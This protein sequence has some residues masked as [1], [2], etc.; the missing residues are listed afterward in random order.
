MRPSKRLILF[1][2]ALSLCS[3][4][5]AQSEDL[6]ISQLSQEVSQRLSL[7]VLFSP[8]IRVEQTVN[9]ELQGGMDAAALYNLFLS[10][11]SV[12]GYSAHRDDNVVTVV[13]H[14]RSRSQPG[15]VITP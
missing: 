1:I 2:L 11:L 15:I 3:P 4:I 7:T 6:S 14:F 12:Y 5:N 13:H 10:A 8:R 9:L